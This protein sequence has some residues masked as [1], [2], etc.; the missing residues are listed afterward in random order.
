[1]RLRE[2]LKQ[3]QYTP[4]HLAEQV[5]LIYAGTKGFLDQVPLNKLLMF[6]EELFTLLAK[7]ASFDFIADL[8]KEKVLTEDLEK[9]L[10]AILEKLQST[11]VD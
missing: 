7:T 6:K 4:L 9:H 2:I 11:Y 8:A 10:V 3:G 1:M 5:A